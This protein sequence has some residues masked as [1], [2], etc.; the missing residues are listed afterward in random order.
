VYGH[1]NSGKTVC[2]TTLNEDCKVSK[3]LQI[4]VTDNATAGEFLQNYRQIWGLDTTSTVGTVMDLRG[5]QKF[6]EPTIGDRIL[7]FNAILDRD[8][9]ISVIAYDYEG[10]AVAIAGGSDLHDKVIDFMDGAHGIMFFYD[11]KLLG[12][13]LESQAHVASFVTML[14]RLAPLSARLPIPVALVVTKADVLPGFSG[15]S[16]TIL[17]GQEDEQ[18]FSEDFETFLEKV[19][20]SNRIASNTAWSSSVR[21]V[22]V[23]LKEFLKVVVGR[24]LDFQVFFVSSTG[25]TPEKVGTD[26][27]R[28]IYKPPRILRPVGLQEPFY[29]ILKSVVRNRSISKFRAVS[30]LVVLLSMIWIAVYSLPHLYHFLYRL[31]QATRAENNILELHSGDYM[32]L[33]DKERPQIIREYDNYSRALTVKWLFPKF[34]PVARQ[35]SETYRNFNIKDALAQLDQTID[36]FT[37]VVSDPMMWPTRNPK[38]SSIVLSED[39][40]KLEADLQQFHAGDSMSLGFRRSDRA[41]SYFDLFKKSIVDPDTNVWSLIMEQVETDKKLYV[42]ELSKAEAGL[43]DA[44]LAKKVVKVKKVEAKS[45]GAKAGGVVDQI[46]DNET[47]EYRLEKAVEELRELRAQLD[48]AA[49]GDV[50]SRVDAYLAEAAKW[51]KARQ[52]FDYRVEKVP[53]DGTLYIE[54]TPHGSNPTWSEFKPVY[55]DEEYSISWMVGDDIHIVFCEANKDC[56]RGADPSDKIVFSSKYSLF[57][58]EKDLHFTNINKHVTLRF[59]PGLIE[60]L[61]KMK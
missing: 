31:P 7:Q 21:S 39:H 28:S 55:Q 51:T 13:E 58:M 6:P 17:V 47:P 35:I 3:H 40:V 2:F 43:M 18:F 46:N 36:R 26:V 5:E 60:R 33:T 19:L 54:V 20:A 34:S 53:D 22:L 25:Q 4:S 30:R 38:D 41:L 15:E 50:V 61:P 29:W 12:A 14:E 48:L 49:S 37:A 16:Q 52:K 32:G 27:G 10:R 8:K 56:K 24:T 45:A 57:E 1:A 9:K 44:L 42:T 59:K 11:P 23:R